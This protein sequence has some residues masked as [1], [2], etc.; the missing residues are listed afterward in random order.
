M[1]MWGV[2]WGL[3]V[4]TGKKFRETMCARALSCLAGR[5]LLAPGSMV[6]PVCS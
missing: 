2:S 5:T 4:L 1:A 3:G 6:T